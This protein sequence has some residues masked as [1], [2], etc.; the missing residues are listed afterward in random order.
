MLYIQ[1]LNE[2]DKCS[3]N[4]IKQK[5]IIMKSSFNLLKKLWSEITY[6]VVYLYNWISC[7][8]LNWKSSYELFHTYLAHQ[9]DVVIEEWKSQQAHLKVYDCKTY[10]MIT[11]TLKKINHLNQLKSRVWINFLVS[12]NSTNIYQIWNL[13]FN[14]VIWTRDIIFD[15]KTVFDD[16]IEAARLELKKIQIVQ[17]MN[18]D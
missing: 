3:E 14:K 4:V 12:Y 10:Y 5:I 1:A 17:N 8:S 11:D 6:V 18:L 2:S 15:E 9:D 13:I 7:Y 16:D